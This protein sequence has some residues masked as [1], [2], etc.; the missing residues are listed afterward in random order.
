M[1]R[2][3]QMLFEALARH[4]EVT[5][6]DAARLLEIDAAV[7]VRLR[8]GQQK[9][10]MTESIGRINRGLKKMKEKAIPLVEWNRE[11][12]VETTG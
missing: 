7:L 10:L 2:G 3:V 4:P 6:A 11:A 1:K 8:S 5:Q 12:E 9:V